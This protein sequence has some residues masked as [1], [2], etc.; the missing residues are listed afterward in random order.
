MAY[1]S[2]MSFTFNYVADGDYAITMR[3]ME[4]NRVWSVG[5]R[6]FYVTVNDQPLL[7]AYDVYAA[8]GTNPVQRILF[9]KVN[10][11][12]IVVRLVSM[13][14]KSNAIVSSISI[15][16]VT[17]P[18]PVFLPRQRGLTTTRTT[19]KIL[20]VSPGGVQ[21]G[22]TFT[23]IPPCVVNAISGAGLLFIAIDTSTLLP[24]C[25]VGI[26]MSGV[27]TYCIA[28]VCTRAQPAAAFT[29]GDIQVATWNM[30]NGAFD[31]LG[32]TDLVGDVS[33]TRVEGTSGI[34]SVI[35]GGKVVL[36]LSDK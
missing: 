15:K 5:S 13:I 27:A 33:S 17:Q 10:E 30:T 3:Y 29:P 25:K 18:G 6:Q 14:E 7:W 23:A 34:N 35:V 20:T 26:S 36:S 24:S 31:E 22:G 8:A 9:R 16:S 21:V 11:G 32:G 28:G 2:N 12:K 19:D 1:G 4:P